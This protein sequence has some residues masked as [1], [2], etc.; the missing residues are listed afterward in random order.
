MLGRRKNSPNT[1][2]QRLEYLREY[3]KANSEHG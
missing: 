3:F 2:R 1:D